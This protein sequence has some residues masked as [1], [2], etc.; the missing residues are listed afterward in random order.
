MCVE[1]RFGQQ[2]LALLNFAASFAPGFD[3]PG[4]DKGLSLTTGICLNRFIHKCPVGLRSNYLTVSSSRLRRVACDL[5]DIG[6][7]TPFGFLGVHIEMCHVSSRVL[8]HSD[9]GQRLFTLGITELVH[10]SIVKYPLTPGQ[11]LLQWLLVLCRESARSLPHS[12]QF[13]SLHNQ[14]ALYHA[15]GSRSQTTQPLRCSSHRNPDTACAL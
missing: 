7:S 2:E 13:P 11:D 9:L 10:G 12:R 3:A 5:A 1:N 8:F 6:T 14:A 15:S 4:N